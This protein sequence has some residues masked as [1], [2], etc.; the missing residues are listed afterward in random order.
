MHKT[1][2][3]WIASVFCL[4]FFLVV[5]LLQTMFKEATLTFNKSEECKKKKQVWGDVVIPVIDVY[6]I[7]DT[8]CLAPI[9]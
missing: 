9:V 8:M 6:K 1:V 7:N 3:L 2:Q 5:F 4:F